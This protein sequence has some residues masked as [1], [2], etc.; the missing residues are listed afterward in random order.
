[1]HC[2]GAAGRPC[3]HPPAEGVPARLS[4]SGDVDAAAVP[5]LLS[6]LTISIGID[7]PHR[8]AALARRRKLAKLASLP[9]LGP[10]SE[11]PAPSSTSGSKPAALACRRMRRR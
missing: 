5:T 10:E 2:D 8:P 9:T 7:A 6:T 1:M 4:G 11:T 3:S